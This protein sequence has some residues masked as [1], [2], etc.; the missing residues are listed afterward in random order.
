MKK[1][2]NTILKKLLSYIH[3][4]QKLPI[5]EKKSSKE[6]NQ[7]LSFIIELKLQKD[8]EENEIDIIFSE[9][10]DLSIAETVIMEKIKVMLSILLH[11][12]EKSID[13]MKLKVLMSSL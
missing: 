10:S 12:S 2:T 8:D 1:I 13:T 3:F 11:S 5:K 6:L 7:L 9:I 4:Y